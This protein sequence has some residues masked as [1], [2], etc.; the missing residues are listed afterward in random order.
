MMNFKVLCATIT[1]G[2]LGIAGCAGKSTDTYKGEAVESGTIKISVT[3][4]DNVAKNESPP[5]KLA[6]QSVVV[7]RDGSKYTVKF[8]NCELSGESGTSTM[9][10]VKNS[11]DVKVANWEGKLPLSATLSF[12]EGGALKMEVIGTSKNDNA[13]VT[14]EWT[15]NGKK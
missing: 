8:G 11:C 10:V 4:T 3:G 14:Y 9:A 5:R 13:V 12:G 2:A 15:F 1:L 6:D 7:T